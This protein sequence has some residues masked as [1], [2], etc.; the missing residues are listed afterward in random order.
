ML[1][2]HSW[3]SLA[4]TQLFRGA[5]YAKMTETN[6]NRIVNKWGVGAGRGSHGVGRVSEGFL[7]VPPTPDPTPINSNSLGTLRL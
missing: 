3:D 6:P 1:A 5:G 7:D 2:G 4:N